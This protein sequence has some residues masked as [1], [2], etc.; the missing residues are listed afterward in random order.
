MSELDSQID[1]MIPWLG[2]V[3]A[4]VTVVLVPM[5]GFF[6]TRSIAQGERLSRLEG[7]QSS[8]GEQ[9]ALLRSEVR[10]GMSELRAEIR[11]AQ[12]VR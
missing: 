2:V 7:Q 1:G 9:V 12:G 4:I 5:V 6:V 10:A 8:V 3:T 11:K